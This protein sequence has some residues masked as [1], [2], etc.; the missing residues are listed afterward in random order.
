MKRTIVQPADLSVEALAEFK[1]W[2][3]ISQPTEDAQLQKLLHASME[4]CESFVRLI[5]IES[6]CEEALP[7]S[8]DWQCL[9]TTPVRAVTGVKAVAKDGLHI[10]LASGDFEIE[11]DADGSGKVRLLTSPSENR[12]TVSF[13]AGIAPDWASLPDGL[14]Q[15]ILRTAAFLYRD[16]DSTSASSLPPSVTSLLTPWRRIRI[17]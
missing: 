14:R 6:G 2:L 12:I 13:V 10:P 15:G 8:C 9:D 11:I 16:R 5:P 7:T 1:Q 3:G 4:L 17:A